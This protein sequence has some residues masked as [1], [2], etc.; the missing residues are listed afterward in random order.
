MVAGLT[1]TGCDTPGSADPTR[2][3]VTHTLPPLTTLTL[4]T[5]VTPPPSARSSSTTSRRSKAGI[6]STTVPSMPGPSTTAAVPGTV[7]PPATSGDCPYLPAADIRYLTG[8]RA[9]AG[10]LI[11]ASPEPICVFTRL[12]TVWVAA[13][14]VFRTPDAASARAAVDERIPVSGSS[15]A[16]RPTGWSGGYMGLP[17]GTSEYPQARSVYGVSAGQY[18]VIV[19]TNQQQSVKARSVV[20]AVIANLRL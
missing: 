14:R 17:D 1:L 13:I 20:E 12:D 18:A 8:Q 5:G 3:T 7:L 4:T 11:S 19:W 2:Q 9:G 10:Q 6:T 15:P 16:D